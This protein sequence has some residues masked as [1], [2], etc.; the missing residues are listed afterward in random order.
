MV[1][2]SSS[3]AEPPAP[4]LT[5]SLGKAYLDAGSEQEGTVTTRT[6]SG[7]TTRG[8]I[9]VHSA[10]SALCPHI[11]WAL[12]GVLGHAVSL[13]WTPQP[14]Q[15]GTYRAEFSWLREAGPGPAGGSA[16]PGGD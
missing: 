8:V 9:Y 6:R 11:E 10:P 4:S 2:T 1:G 12:G 15:A 3:H 5:R 16:P 7:A 14:A 13:E